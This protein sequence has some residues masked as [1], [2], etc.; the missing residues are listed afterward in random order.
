MIYESIDQCLSD[1]RIG[2]VYSPGRK[3][4]LGLRKKKQEAWKAGSCV[5]WALKKF[6]LSGNL[7]FYPLFL[8]VTSIQKLMRFQRKIN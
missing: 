3:A 6:Q 8:A 1:L 2:P 5:T 7:K 4:W